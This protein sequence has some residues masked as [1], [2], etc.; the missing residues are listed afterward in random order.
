MSENNYKYL[1]G[2]ED[3]LGE[4]S[5]HSPIR[6]IILGNER[7][8]SISIDQLITDLDCSHEEHLFSEEMYLCDREITASYIFF[9]HADIASSLEE[10]L[11]LISQAKIRFSGMKEFLLVCKKYQTLHSHDIASTMIA[12]AVGA[13]VIVFAS[14]R[15]RMRTRWELYTVGIE[16]F[17]AFSNM[18]YLAMVS[19]KEEEQGTFFS[20]SIH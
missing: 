1:L 10:L 4:G 15:T 18:R 16:K 3:V 9:L 19:L 12:T 13:M 8:R 2:K 14:R 17:F 20:R 11:E 6:D 7:F 5:L